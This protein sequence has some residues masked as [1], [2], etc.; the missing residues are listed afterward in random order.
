MKHNYK[1]IQKEKIQNKIEK[2]K[3]K[4]TEK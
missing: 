1:N 3:K 2:M 4:K